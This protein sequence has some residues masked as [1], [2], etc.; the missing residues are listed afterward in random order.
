MGFVEQSYLCRSIHESLLAFRPAYGTFRP[1]SMNEVKAA[2][3]L[4]FLRQS[5]YYRQFVVT[6]H[7]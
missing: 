7:L 1:P 4:N 2:C 3:L 5:P 6:W